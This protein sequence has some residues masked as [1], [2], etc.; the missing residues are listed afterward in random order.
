MYTETGFLK[1]E[2]V[3]R[4]VCG[5]IKFKQA[6]QQLKVT[7]RTIHNYCSRFLKEGPKGLKDR[8]SGNHYKLSPLEESA[9][10]SFKTQRPRRSARLIRDRLRLRVSEEA[11]RLI[12]VKH[13][14]SGTGAIA[15]LG[16]TPLSI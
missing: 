14:L 7:S 6:A 9:I 3:R 1:E 4:V 16:P 12:L 10:V 5:E 11:V 13:R 15:N 2:V 8:R